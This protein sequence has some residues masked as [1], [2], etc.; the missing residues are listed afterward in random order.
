MNDYEGQLEELR[1]PL[2]SPS[3]KPCETIV[4]AP[5]LE[6]EKRSRGVIIIDMFSWEEDDG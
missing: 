6:K 1:L 5:E 3:L 2:P 4:I